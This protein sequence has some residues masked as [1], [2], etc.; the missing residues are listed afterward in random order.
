MGIARWCRGVVVVMV[1]A[2]ALSLVTGT[3]LTT[4]PVDRTMA[5]ATTVTATTVPA[6][7]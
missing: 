3:I 1:A 6:D 4:T 7:H 2:P 5:P